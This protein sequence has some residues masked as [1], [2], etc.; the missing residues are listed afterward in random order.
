M[1]A[2]KQDRVPLTC[3]HCG[4]QQLEPRTAFSSVC[5]KCGQHLRV[6][7]ILRPAHAAVEAVPE[8]KQITCFDCGAVLEVPVSAESTMCKRCSA[9]IDLKDY[10]INNAVS[11]NFKTKGTFV[12]EA[13]GYVFNTEV[14]VGSAVI[15]G[16]LHGKLNAEHALTV[17]STAEIKGT[18]KTS[19]LIIPAENHFRWKEPLAVNSAE[20]AGEIAADF[21][22]EGT[23]VLKSTARLFGNVTAKNLVVEEG[24]VVV[25]NLRIGGDVALEAR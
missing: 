17:Y 7:E 1:P 13:K 19:R 5:K 3:P 23:V 18:F 16:R 2:S 6:Q 11:K 21:K 25:G 8:R 20:I 9:Y 12:V 24:A 4:H 10:R 22:A 15:R 14:V